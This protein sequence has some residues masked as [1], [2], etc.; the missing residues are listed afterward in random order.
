MLSTSFGTAKHVL[1]DVNMCHQLCVSTYCMVCWRAR[2]G[3][4]QVG[5]SRDE[6]SELRGLEANAPP[7]PGQPLLLP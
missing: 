7:L 6:R 1:V 4:L 2:L 3:G 5:A